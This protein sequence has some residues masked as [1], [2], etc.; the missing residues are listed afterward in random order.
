MRGRSV[1]SASS[2]KTIGLAKHAEYS[3]YEKVAGERDYDAIR[4][5]FHRNPYSIKGVNHAGR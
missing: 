3:R 2:S 5:R 1:K 4:E